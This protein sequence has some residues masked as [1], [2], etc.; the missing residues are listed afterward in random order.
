[1]GD[2]RRQDFT[3][4]VFDLVLAYGVLHC[5]H[6]ESDVQTVVARL[7]SATR[8][9]GFHVVCS[10]N[11]RLQELEAHPGFAPC[12]LTHD[13]FVRM[14]KDWDL[15]LASDSDLVETHPHNGIRHRHSLTR[16]IARKRL[17]T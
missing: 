10:F 12:L 17:F 14:Y 8:P 3:G 1:V 5:L 6:D 11:S 16:I 15:L 4:N 9:G 2:I 7:N 13:F